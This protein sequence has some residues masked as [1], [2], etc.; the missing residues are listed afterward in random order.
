[1]REPRG[2]HTT[3]STVTGSRLLTLGPTTALVGVSG[4]PH[5]VDNNGTVEKRLTSETLVRRDLPPLASS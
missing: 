2:G 1:M 4:R 5:H 3:V